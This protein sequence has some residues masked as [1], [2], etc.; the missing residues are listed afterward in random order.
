MLLN[1][2]IRSGG[3]EIDFEMKIYILPFIIKLRILG[4]GG[5]AVEVSGGGGG[6]G[7]RLPP[8]VRMNSYIRAGI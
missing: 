8:T 6:G 3:N 2:F 5:I 4:F 1:L 7:G